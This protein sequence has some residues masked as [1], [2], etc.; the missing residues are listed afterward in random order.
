M[1]PNTRPAASALIRTSSWYH[2]RL[3]RAAWLLA[4]AIA[5]QACATPPR[6]PLAGASDSWKQEPEPGADAAAPPIASAV[7]EG[8]A[9]LQREPHL[10]SA[11]FTARGHQPEQAVDV[12]ANALAR[13]SYELL[14]TDTVFP[15]GALLA[16]LSRSHVGHSY[17]M[18][19]QAG[20][21]SYLELDER[22][23]LLSQGSPA[24]CV[25]CHAQA[26]ADHVFGLPRPL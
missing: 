24:P 20:S 26:P 5:V 19:K 12:I 17:V 15:D 21:W 8:Y 22:G 1:A 2:A 9:P 25:A 14:V 7:W 4:F 13:P 3:V 10:N 18:R 16:L 11:P 6:G 23:A